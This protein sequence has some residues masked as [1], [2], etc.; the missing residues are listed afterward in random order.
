MPSFAEAVAQKLATDNLPVADA[1]NKI[2]VSLMGL[3]SV[4]R[5]KS[6]PNARSVGKYAEFLGMPGEALAALI[7]ESK[8]TAPV[9]GKGGRKAKAKAEK[10]EAEPKEKPVRKAAKANTI[11]IDAIT[12]ALKAANAVLNDDLV[13]KLS[14]L[15]G[16]KRKAAEAILASVI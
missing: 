5:G 16:P 1:A 11:D 8:A 10:S 7:K 13:L 14:A 15:S 6:F 2:G 4:L 9:K 12:A 3:R